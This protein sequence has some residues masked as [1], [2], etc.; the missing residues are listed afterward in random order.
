MPFSGPGDPELPDNVKKLPATKKRQWV[1][2]FNSAFAKCMKEG[3]SDC[4]GSAFRQANSVALAKLETRDFL[5]VPI[6]TVGTFDAETGPV[7]FSRG[8]L[9]DM[10][11][12]NRANPNF[13]AP[14]KFGH[15][16][17]Q[18]L[19]EE[20]ELPAAGWV[21]NLRRIGDTLIADLMRVPAKIADLI[22]AGAFRKRSI[23]S[24]FDVEIGGRSWPTVLTGLAL[25]G[26]KLPA[27]GSLDDIVGLYSSLNLEAED[28]VAIS[29]GDLSPMLPSYIQVLSDAAFAAKSE[30]GAYRQLP[31]HTIKGTVDRIRLVRSIEELPQIKTSV[32]L[33]RRML[34]HLSNH[35]QQEGM[36][37]N[38]DVQLVTEV[39]MEEEVRK[40]LGLGEADDVLAT[41]KGLVE[42][43]SKLREILKLGEGEDLLKKVTELSAQKPPDSDDPHKGEKK[44]ENGDAPTKGNEI[45][46]ASLTKDLASANQRILTLEGTEG[47]RSAEVLVDEAIQKGR[48]IPAQRETAVKLAIA[49][50]SDF[51]AY[52]KTSPEGQ[53]PMGEKGQAGDGIAADLAALEPTPAQ[54]EAAK[55]LNI[56]SPQHRIE[57]MRENAKEK[58]VELPTNF[59]KEEK[60]D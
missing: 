1:S 43:S 28:G 4:E 57:L 42:L 23:E 8:R 56:W 15:G 12:A 30:G 14:I 3:G 13:Q 17:D 44:G 22:D 10:V 25:L 55:A 35:A 49:S 38:K 37:I 21:E 50:G 58:G 2:V 53:V 18:D 24:M 48:L 20:S 29:V 9:D 31:H 16:E 39:L 60:K 54:V 52:L 33:K 51:E 27:V 59:G 6:L 46:V 45:A 40:L 36:N 26:S 47:R 34:S 19:L 41:V 7:T 5:S 32:A 11:E